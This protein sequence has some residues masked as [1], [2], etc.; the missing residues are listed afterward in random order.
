MTVL[1]SLYNMIIQIFDFVEIFA[2]INDQL[3]CIS[4]SQG[5][6]YM[7]LLVEIIFW[8]FHFLPRKEKM[9]QKRWRINILKEV[10]QHLGA[11]KS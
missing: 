7:L 11:T 2:F 6:F 5:V 8:R 4:T 1:L 3:L 10:Y 9:N